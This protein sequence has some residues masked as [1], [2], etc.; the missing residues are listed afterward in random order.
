MTI[1]MGAE[2][3][4]KGRRRKGPR[5]AGS[6]YQYLTSYKGLTFYTKSSAPLNL[7]WGT[8]VVLA[9]SI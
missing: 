3:E 5:R 4:P 8:E 9:K 2:T 1:S 6:T 7:T